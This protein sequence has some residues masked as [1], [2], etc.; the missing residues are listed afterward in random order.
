VKTTPEETAVQS[1]VTSFS[2]EFSKHLP[3]SVVSMV[4]A[5]KDCLLAPVEERHPLEGMFASVIG[6]ALAEV[7]TVLAQKLDEAKAENVEAAETLKKLDSDVE[8]AVE[9]KAT[10]DSELTAAQEAE[11]AAQTAVREANEA[12]AT[13][14]AEEADL[15]PK[16]ERLEAERDVLQEAL[17]IARGPE[18]SKKDSAK[19]TKTLKDVGGPEALVL[20]VVAAIGK[21]G[22]LEQI[23][24]NQACSLIGA[25][26]DTIKAELSAFDETVKTMAT[27]TGEMKANVE[28][29]AATLEEKEQA[30]K[31]AKEKQKSCAAAI[32]AAEK[33][34]KAGAKAVEKTG[35]NVQMASAA[36]TEATDADTT[37][38][39][40]LTRSS[41][42]EAAETE[43]EV[44]ES[45]EPDPFATQM[46]VEP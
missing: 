11:F 18:P 37:F 33:A 28:A 17:D 34:Q 27:K 12:L 14:E 46:E 22:Q 31:L 6:D 9:A 29:L 7:G 39:S 3:A 42:P 8:G 38:K 30:V 13:Q 1:L 21:E 4:I 16:K 2:G 43:P 10:A 26:H 35:D 15:M 40:L 36:S 45:K 41:M 44:E 32:K 25:K 20:G 24:I 23:F 19:V 5:S